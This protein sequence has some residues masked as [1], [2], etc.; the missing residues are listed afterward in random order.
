MGARR[1]ELI[2]ADRVIVPA[3]SADVRGD[4][5]DELIDALR[6]AHGRGAR[7]LSLCSGAFT[8]AAT[9]LLDGRTAATHWMYAA[10][11]A[12]RCPAVRIDPSVLYVGP[13]DVLI[14]GHPRPA[15]A[16]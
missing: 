1:K 14:T 3:A 8:L 5:P 16:P 10:L 12:E 4:P 9:G 7:I 2:S 11:F 13:G 15:A 6:E